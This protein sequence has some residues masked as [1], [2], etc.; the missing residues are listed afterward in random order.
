MKVVH[1]RNNPR[2][3]KLQIL[4]PICFTFA[5]LRRRGVRSFVLA[6]LMLRKMLSLCHGCCSDVRWWGKLMKKVTR[7]QEVRIFVKRHHVVRGV[8]NTGYEVGVRVAVGGVS[9]GM[10][11]VLVDDLTVTAIVVD[12]WKIVDGD[13]WFGGVQ[14]PWKFVLGVVVLGV[15]LLVRTVVAY[16][17]FGGVVAFAIATS[18]VSILMLMVTLLLREGGGFL[19]FVVGDLEEVD[20]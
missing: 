6:A 9:V 19:L 5:L 18:P 13:H 10:V 7:V 20:L 4:R 1:R 17:G 12:I 3:W 8:G 16:E 14:A 2:K 11:E 15:F